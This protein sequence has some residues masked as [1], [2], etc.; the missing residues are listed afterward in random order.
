MFSRKLPT[1][2]DDRSCLSLFWDDR[3]DFRE[4][5]FM[6]AMYFYHILFSRISLFILALLVPRGKVRE[7]V[8]HQKGEV[9]SILLLNLY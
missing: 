8:K 4:N 7:T 5:I 9:K 3:Y 1:G 6:D 2:A